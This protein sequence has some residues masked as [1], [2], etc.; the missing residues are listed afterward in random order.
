M[1]VEFIYEDSYNN[2]SVQTY[3]TELVTANDYIISN[4]PSHYGN[5]SFPSILRKQIHEKWLGRKNYY[6][7]YKTWVT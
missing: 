2:V 7:I 5:E 1:L 4:I 6:N 3:G